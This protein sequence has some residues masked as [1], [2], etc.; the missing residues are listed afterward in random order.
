MYIPI[1]ILFAGVIVYFYIKN[2]NKDILDDVPRNI[3]ELWELA[4]SY[5]RHVLEKSP[6]LEDYLQ[7][8]RDMINSMERD[9]IRL[10]ERYKHDSEKQKHIANDWVDFAKAIWDTKSARERLDVN[11]GDDA[12]D[13]FDEATKEAFIV[14]QEIT[15]RVIKDLGEDSAMKIVGDRMK[16]RGEDADDILNK[17]NI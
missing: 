3:D 11:V 9:M 7:D 17:N 13:I 4:E 8:E 6:N 12:Y 10:K 1:W 14:T 15:E 16:K 5:K 2:R